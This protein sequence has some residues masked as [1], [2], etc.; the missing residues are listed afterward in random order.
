MVSVAVT[1]ANDGTSPGSLRGLFQAT[2]GGLDVELMAP[3][4]AHEVSMGPVGGVGHVSAACGASPV[5][6]G[7][8]L[9]PN[10]AQ[11]DQEYRKG[12]RG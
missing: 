1:R 4:R 6:S 3:A 12:K 2:G 5:V 7:L 11:R 10:R 9:N 8:P